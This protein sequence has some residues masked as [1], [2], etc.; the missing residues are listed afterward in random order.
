MYNKINKITLVLVVAAAAYAQDAPPAAGTLKVGEVSLTRSTGKFSAGPLGTIDILQDGAGAAFSSIDLS[1]VVQSDQ[2]RDVTIIDPCTISKLGQ[3]S[4]GNNP[5]DSVTYLDAG[6]A[7]NLTG[8]KGSKQV[9]VVSKML[10][11]AMLGWRHS[12]SRIAR[13]SSALF[14]A[15]GLYRQQRSRGC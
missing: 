15:W 10:Y 3:P 4:N 2:Q 6:P 5:N 8:P 12:D 14:G 1:K 7:L 9:P 13:A 11:G